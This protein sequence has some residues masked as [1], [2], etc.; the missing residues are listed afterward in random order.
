MEKFD[1][2][3]KKEK[4]I[5]CISVAFKEV[6]RISS[7]ARDPTKGSNYGTTFLNI[8]CIGIKVMVLV[9]KLGTVGLNMRSIFRVVC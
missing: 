3:F 5:N 1:G 6:S 4:L 9:E 7:R 2:V 8:N